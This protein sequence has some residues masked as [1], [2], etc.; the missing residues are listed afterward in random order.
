[1]SFLN[2]YLIEINEFPQSGKDRNLYTIKDYFYYDS[3]TKE[4][5]YRNLLIPVSCLTNKESLPSET[6]IKELI[7]NRI[8]VIKREVD[9]DKN[10]EIWSFEHDY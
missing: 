1:M 4:Y 5:G 9:L 7:N 6:V 3:N 10:I 2:E 8:P